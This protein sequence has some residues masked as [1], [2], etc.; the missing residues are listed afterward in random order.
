MDYF[1]IPDDAPEKIFS[2]IYPNIA[3]GIET[4]AAKEESWRDQA[5]FRKFDQ[6]LFIP[7]EYQDDY[8][9]LW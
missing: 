1:V 8:T 3:G 7:E 6:S 5:I 2:H 9:G 4:L